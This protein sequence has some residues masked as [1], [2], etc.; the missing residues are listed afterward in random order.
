MKSSPAMSQVERFKTTARQLECDE[1]T[2]RFETKL[3]RI[4]TAK[5]PQPKT[6]EK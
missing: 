5:P 3:K 2:E 6:D 1:D 4:A